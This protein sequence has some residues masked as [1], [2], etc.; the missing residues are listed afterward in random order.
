[1]GK[2]I[3]IYPPGNREFLE[4]IEE[5]HIATTGLVGPYILSDHRY[6]DS[7]TVFYRY[8]GMRLYEV[9]NVNGEKTPMLVAPDGTEVPD[10]RLAYPIT[11]SWVTT[12]L[13]MAESQA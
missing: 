10:Q 8:G 5:L 2:F 1:S 6:K 9:L 7:A 11:P 3:T 13:P 4:L 12:L